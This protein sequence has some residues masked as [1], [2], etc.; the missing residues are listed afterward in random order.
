VDCHASLRGK[1]LVGHAQ[2]FYGENG[3]AT[4]ACMWT[5]PTGA[6]GKLVAWMRVYNSAGGYAGSGLYRWRVK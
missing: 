3:I 1:Q 2:K 6:A 4:I 5:I